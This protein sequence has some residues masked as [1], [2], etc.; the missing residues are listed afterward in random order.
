M[1]M[2]LLMMIAMSGV[3]PDAPPRSLAKPCLRSGGSMVRLGLLGSWSCVHHFRDG[4]KQC[5]DGA[6]CDS[7]LCLAERSQPPR[8]ASRATGGLCA[9]TN[10][11]FGCHAR[12]VK[13][14]VQP[15][16]CVD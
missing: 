16:L 12:V 8:R 10:N 1:V 2:S 6:Q 5:G 7:G 13:G 14:R 11:P 3:T 4:G 15:F 9:P